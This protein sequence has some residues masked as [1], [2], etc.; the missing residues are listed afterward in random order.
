MSTD[1]DASPAI[2]KTR[3]RL[4]T[5]RL[6][7]VLVL[8]MGCLAIAAPFFAGPLALFLCGLLLIVCGVLDGDVSCRG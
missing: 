8:L 2:P 7:G 3:G 1:A 4:G 6:R 5:A